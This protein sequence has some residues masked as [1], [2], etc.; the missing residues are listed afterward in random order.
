MTDE[1]DYKQREGEPPFTGMMRINA[2][3]R[4]YQLKEGTYEWE[5]MY[6]TSDFRNSPYDRA[7]ALLSNTLHERV[8]R[9]QQLSG[10]MSAEG[11][12]AAYA[13]N[14]VQ[15]LT[16]ERSFAKAL[17]L[18]QGDR[19]YVEGWR[20]HFVGKVGGYLRDVNDGNYQLNRMQVPES[21]RD[22]NGWNA[23]CD[24]KKKK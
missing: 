9:A 17:G 6:K 11:A 18:T 7:A 1:G 5:R 24:P 2:A 14:E 22:Q 21:I 13:V 3:L 23:T 20:A 12:E 10:N 8:H 15:A 19:A 4:S 16:V